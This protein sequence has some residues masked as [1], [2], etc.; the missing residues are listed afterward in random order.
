MSANR[1]QVPDA[2][3]LAAQQRARRRSVPTR[4]ST[5]M[6]RSLQER[7]RE[8]PRSRARRLTPGHPD[9]VVHAIAGRGR[10]PCPRA[11]SVQ[12]NRAACVSPS[13]QG[14]GPITPAGIGSRTSAVFPQNMTT[15]GPRI[16]PHHHRADDAGAVLGI[17][18][19][20]RF[21]PTRPVAGPSGIDDACARHGSATTRWWS[22]LMRRT[23]RTTMLTMTA[24]GRMLTSFRQC[25][26]A[27]LR[28]A[29]MASGARIPP[30]APGHGLERISH[31]IA[32]WCRTASRG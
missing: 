15:I 26:R 28:C 4:P 31:D 9:G 25:R 24:R 8:R 30:I 19:A 5:L 18:N 1:K 21:A 32:A 13:A 23:T 7:W 6:P 2:A 14:G 20:L 12:E 29:T 16:E 27:L 17:D 10:C 11:W 3:Y 22:D